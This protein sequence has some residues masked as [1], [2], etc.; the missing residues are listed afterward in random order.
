MTWGFPTIHRIPDRWE[1]DPRC[2]PNAIC[3]IIPSRNR[4]PIGV[5]PACAPTG[6]TRTTDSAGKQVHLAVAVC[7]SSSGRSSTLRVTV[8]TPRPRYSSS[9]GSLHAQCYRY[10]AWGPRVC[11]RHLKRQVPRNQNYPSG[12]GQ[13]WACPHSQVQPGPVEPTQ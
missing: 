9:A 5:Q 7:E 11:R 12:P 10:S 8:C 2:L 6:S 1:S 13:Y 3:Q 4:H